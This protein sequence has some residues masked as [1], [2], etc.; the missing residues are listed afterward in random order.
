MTQARSAKFRSQL[1][2]TGVNPFVSI[3]ANVAAR[4]RKG[5]RPIPVRFQINKST[6]YWSVNM[7]PVRGGTFR[8]YLNGEI[9]KAAG[10]KVGD[11]LEVKVQFDDEYK[12]GPLHPLPSWFS[13]PLSQNSKAL[14]RWRLLTPSKKK[15]ILRY[16]AGLKS[17]EAKERNL[18]R[19]LHV[20]AGGQGRFLGVAWNASQ[21]N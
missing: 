4:L 21:A 13:K 2:I 11:S 1:E 20:L 3:S 12:N 18:V 17:P 14:K 6:K 8:L 5:R 19:A 10:L 15:E 16:F 7:M 9:R